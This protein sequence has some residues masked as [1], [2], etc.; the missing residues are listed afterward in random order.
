MFGIEVNALKMLSVCV[1]RRIITSCIFEKKH[2]FTHFMYELNSFFSIFKVNLTFTAAA[3]AAAAASVA[4]TDEREKAST[5]QFLIHIWLILMK[6]ISIVILLSHCRFFFSFVFNFF[7]RWIECE[8]L[9]FYV[10]AIYSVLFFFFSRTKEMK[11][12]GMN[13]LY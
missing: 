10:G 1:R 8:I 7:A 6:P 4:A 13:Y 11:L 9:W 5:L 12:C 2:I 3:A